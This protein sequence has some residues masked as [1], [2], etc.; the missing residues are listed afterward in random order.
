MTDALQIP[1]LPTNL[2]TAGAATISNLMSSGAALF[3]NPVASS[4]TS[5][6]AQI[7][8][9]SSSLTSLSSNVSSLLGS[10]G[11]SLVSQLGSL[12]SSL[13]S[14]GSSMGSLL[15]HTNSLI[16]GG[17]SSILSGGLM[18][19]L[20]QMLSGTGIKNFLYG[21]NAL[22]VPAG[23]TNLSQFFGSLLGA[24]ASLVSGATSQM[25]AI[26]SLISGA[27]SL[28][29]KGASA[30]TAGISGLM[31]QATAAM[32]GMSSVASQ[33]TSKITSELGGF[34]SLLNTAMNFIIAH[35]VANNFLNACS[36]PLMSA[37][38]TPALQNALA[39]IFVDSNPPAT[40][41]VPPV[42]GVS[43]NTQGVQ[44]TPTTTAIQNLL[45]A[46]LVPD[47][48]TGSKAP[49]L[50]VATTA[51]LGPV[52]GFDSPQ[53]IKVP[54]TNEQ[55][56]VD[57]QTSIS[58]AVPGSVVGGQTTQPTQTGESRTPDNSISGR[59]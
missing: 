39:N 51:A 30:L 38:G 33:I 47:S 5:A 22:P 3:T 36:L 42:S 53:L 45:Q 52:V 1:T 13:S 8:N 50:N 41:T 44:T 7:P 14:M 4:I 59:C 29:S 6:T 34:A 2:T 37:V 17:G 35:N 24:G 21:F 49:P 19:N 10:N 12:G 23:C 11:A 20:Q 57:T 58:G 54:L 26:G 31:S 56:F 32:S 46:S 48:S 18:N 27:Q 28:I 40:T 16:S 55:P 9:L 25:G 15:D 43:Y